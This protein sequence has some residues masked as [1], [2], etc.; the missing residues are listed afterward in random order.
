MGDSLID[1]PLTDLALML[2]LVA[3]VVGLSAQQRFGL[4]RTLVWATLRCLVQLFAV[5]YVLLW[6]FQVD[7]W[8]IVLAVVAV[9]AT[10]A[11]ITAAGRI[12]FALPRGRL[13][14][15]G[16]IALASGLALVF[17]L[18]VVV[19]PATWWEP[20]YFIPLAGIFLGNAMNAAALG[21]E[22]LA[23]SIR[24]SRLEIETMLALGLPPVEACHRHRREAFRAALMPTVNTMFVI[25]IVTLPGIMTG[26][27][28]SGVSPLLA[29][30]YQIFI[31]FSLTFGNVLAAW[32]TGEA[33]WRRHFNR[34]WQLIEL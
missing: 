24:S 25:G 10:V 5:G 26:Q 14:T 18:A 16:A 8:W 31:M 12:E 7:R 13:I 19:R 11:G 33:I 34:A 29:A 1:L 15:T 22:R 28:L 3:V 32:V 27:M 21:G 2:A 23:S 30:K 9:M 17:G 20:Q 4:E 6:V